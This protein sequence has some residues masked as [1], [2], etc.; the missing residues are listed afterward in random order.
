MRSPPTAAATTGV[1]QACASSATRPND[2]ECDGTSTIVAARYQSASS[3]C[4]HGGSNR[5]WPETPSEAASAPSRPGAP[6]SDPLGPPT[7]TTTSRS[8]SSGATR[9]S[10]AAARSTTSGP[11]SGWIRPAK[12]ST[13]ASG[14]SPSRCRT[15]AAGAA[16]DTGRNTDRSTPGLTV[17]TCCGRAPYSSI[18]WRASSAVLAISR[19]AAATTSSSPRILTAGSAQSP[20][21]SARFLTLPRVCMDCTSGTPQRSAATAPT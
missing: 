12:T 5:T 2:S 9:S 6:T 3:R 18:S 11:F 7:K 14:G 8:A 10:D 19:S 15:A 1:P 20:L 17:F 21:A 16:A 13:T 4:E